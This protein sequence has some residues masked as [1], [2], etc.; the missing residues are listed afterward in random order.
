MS[1]AHID[2]SANL[3]DQLCVHEARNAG[4]QLFM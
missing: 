3:P 2:E 4:M 1:L